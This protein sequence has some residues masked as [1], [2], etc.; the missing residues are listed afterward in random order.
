MKPS[1]ARKIADAAVE[2]A[3][4]ELIT[5]VSLDIDMLNCAVDVY[6]DGAFVR[7]FPLTRLLLDSY[8]HLTRE[9]REWE[10]SFNGANEINRVFRSVSGQLHRHYRKQEKQAK[11]DSGVDSG[12]KEKAEK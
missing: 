2:A 7:R 12:K 1:Q 5:R 8:D 6:I 10:I 3:I 4:D 11:V 9:T